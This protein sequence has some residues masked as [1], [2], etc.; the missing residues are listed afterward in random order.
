MTDDQY[1]WFE[2]GGGRWSRAWAYAVRQALHIEPKPEGRVSRVAF[3]VLADG[4]SIYAQ[5]LGIGS[6][7]T[8]VIR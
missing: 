1:G 8:E 5:A 4:W 7:S 2:Q 6:L 3:D